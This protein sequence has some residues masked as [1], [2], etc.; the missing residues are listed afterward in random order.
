VN[1]YT[2][3][4][5]VNCISIPYSDIDQHAKEFQKI[6]ATPVSDRDIPTI[7]AWRKARYDAGLSSEFK[8]FYTV[9]GF[10]FDCKGTGWRSKDG[11]FSGVGHLYSECSVCKGTGKTE[12]GDQ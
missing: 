10:C 3:E 7:K 4:N 1:R 8:D 12:G 6:T 5:G 9:N 2:D 11:S